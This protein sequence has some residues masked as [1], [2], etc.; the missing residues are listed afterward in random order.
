MRLRVGVI[1]WSASAAL[2]ALLRPTSRACRSTGRVRSDCASRRNRSAEFDCAAAIGPVELLE[3]SDVEAVLLLDSLGY[4]LWPL[5]HASASTAG[6][7]HLLAGHDEAHAEPSA[8][9]QSSI[10]PC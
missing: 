5:E 4:G 3:R 10:L 6:P 9:D 2:S 1:V 8:D 7:L